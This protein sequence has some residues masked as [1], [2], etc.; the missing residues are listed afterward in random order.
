MKQR[1]IFALSLAAIVLVVSVAF[2]SGNSPAFKNESG[3]AVA[4][5]LRN[6][7]FALLPF[8]LVGG[9]HVFRKGVEKK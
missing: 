4:Q 3:K 6:E 2:F 1:R 8:L 7:K 9:V 5:Q